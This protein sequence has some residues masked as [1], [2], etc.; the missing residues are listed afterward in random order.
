MSTLKHKLT[1]ARY[2][3]RTE[4]FPALASAGRKFFFGSNESYDDKLAHMM[5]LPTAKDRFTKIHEDNLWCGTDSLSGEGSNLEST[6]KL[7][8]ALPKLISA[9]DIHSMVDAPCGDFA[10]MRFI[11]P[12]LNLDYTGL[13]IVKKIIHV[14]QSNFA[15]DNIR[16]LESDICNDPIPVADMIFIR[17]CLFHLSFQ[18][19]EKILQN[20]HAT[21]YKYLMTTTHD[22]QD[23]A[24]F[25]NTDILSG[26]FRRIDL[27]SAPFGFRRDSVL[28]QVEDFEPG[29]LPRSM[30]LIAKKDVPATLSI[31]EPNKT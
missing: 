29:Q 14:N 2:I 9:Y 18:D 30:V 8:Q 7:R 23:S 26:D 12:D 1:R 22:V 4:G 25:Q 21:D 11:L 24:V 13:D 6:R 17:D 27:F 19:I 5:A 20:L 16:F 31:L 15:A 3:L 10:W 28:E